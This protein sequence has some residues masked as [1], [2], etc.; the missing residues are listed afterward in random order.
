MKAVIQRVKQAAVTVDGA[1]IGAINKGFMILLGVHEEDTMAEVDWLAEKIVKMGI[2]SD[3]NDK[4]NLAIGDVGGDI[5]L[6]SQFALHAATHKGNRPSYITAAKPSIAIPL[7]EAMIA[8]LTALLGKPI[9]TG[10]FG[11]MMDVSL[12]NDGPVTIII[13]TKNP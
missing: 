4:M 11:A 9:A 3:E 7:Y 8:K 13:D 6:V 2:F 5:L 10:Q 1:V 12:I